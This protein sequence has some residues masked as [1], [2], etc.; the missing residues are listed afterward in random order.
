MVSFNGESEI[1]TPHI[2]AESLP[3][4]SI[5]ITG[6]F[7]LGVIFLHFFLNIPKGASV[8]ALRTSHEFIQTCFGSDSSV[9]L[10]AD[11]DR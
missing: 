11:F 7:F 5:I 6:F 2:R 4:V 8:E 3:I 1:F 9:N 10:T